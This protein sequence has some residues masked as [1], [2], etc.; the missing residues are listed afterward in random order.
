M[1]KA[2][3]RRFAT[4][5]PKK[6]YWLLFK[7]RPTDKEWSDRYVNQLLEDSPEINQAAR[8]TDEF[9]RLMKDRQAAKLRN[10]LAEAQKSGISELAGFARG[11]HLDFKAVEAAF[12][13]E[14]SNGRTEGQVNRLKFIKRQIYGR[15]NFDLLRA[16]VVHQ[17]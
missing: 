1:V 7:P 13:S 5:S 14:W 16:R 9:F 10:W 3:I 17:N 2:K 4:P 12:S 8:L 15:A 6:T 11:I